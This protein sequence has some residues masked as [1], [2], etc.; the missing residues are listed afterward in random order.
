[1]FAYDQATGEQ[2]IYINDY[3]DYNALR[4]YGEDETY[5]A[6]FPYT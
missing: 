2:D 5:D 4:L 1:M 6:A 3:A